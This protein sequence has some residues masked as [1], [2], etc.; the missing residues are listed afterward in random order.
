[1]PGA[2]AAPLP[3]F[4]GASAIRASL[5][6]SKRRHA[7]RVLQRGAG[8]LRRIDDTGFDQVFVDVGRGVVADVAF[9]LDDLFA[10]DAAVLAGV[11]GDRGQRRTAGTRDDLV[12][13]LL[14][15]AQIVSA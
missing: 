10:D 14:I 5:V 1:M 4:F 6:S 12:A 3:S 7:G 13:N 8:D 9:R 2:A 11:A 15:V